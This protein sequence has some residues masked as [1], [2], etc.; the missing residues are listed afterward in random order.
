MKKKPKVFSVILSVLLLLALLAMAGC[1]VYIRKDRTVGDIERFL[2]YISSY[3]SNGDWYPVKI[4]W[5]AS[6]GAVILFAIIYGLIKFSRKQFP[7]ASLFVTFGYAGLVTAW[8]YRAKVELYFNALVNNDTLAQNKK[9]VGYIFFGA[10]AFVI[11]YLVIAVLVAVVKDLFLSRADNKVK[12]IKINGIESQKEEVQP[13]PQPEPEPEPVLEIQE[14]IVIEET[15]E[16]K[17][18][19]IIHKTKVDINDSTDIDEIE[20]LVEN[21]KREIAKIRGIEYIEKTVIVEEEEAEDD[22]V[23]ADDND[24]AE[25]N[26][27]VEQVSQVIEIETNPFFLAAKEKAFLAKS[28]DFKMRGASDEVKSWFSGIKNE[29]LSYKKVRS[30]ISRSCN[31]FRRGRNLLVKINIVGKTLKIYLALDVNNY[32]YNRYR[33]KDVSD[34][35]KYELVP[36]MI[37][38]KSNRSYNRVLELIADLMKKFECVKNPKFTSIDYVAAYQPDSQ[39]VLKSLGLAHLLRDR[40]DVKEAGVLTDEQASA[41]SQVVFIEKPENFVEVNAVLNIDD[42]AKVFDKNDIVNLTTLKERKLIGRRINN[43]QIRGLGEVD[44]PLTV[45]ANDFTLTA[46]KMI[47]LTGGSVVEYK[48]K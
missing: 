18:K 2:N 42:I 12:K 19:A 26:G 41:L 4:W 38:V 39:N 45:C 25:D 29:L 27:D 37:R 7:F 23:D 47:V 36:F 16:D 1:V 9:I 21:A 10:L 40:I 30:R 34:T 44:K 6:S 22:D 3:L 24:D 13:E 17:I 46:I 8:H 14:E 33:Q 43:V 48:Q 35:R 20:E 15:D 31:S 11:G 32:D 5:V 28:F